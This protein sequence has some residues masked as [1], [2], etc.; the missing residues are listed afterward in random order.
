MISVFMV[1]DHKSK[2]QKSTLLFC[3]CKLKIAWLWW[4]I[5]KYI[6]H[7]PPFRPGTAL[8]TEVARKQQLEGRGANKLN[9]RTLL[10]RT[11]TQ[12]LFLLL[13]KVKPLG[14]RHND[15]S[16][17]GKALKKGRNI[18]DQSS[19]LIHN[20]CRGWIQHANLW[21][22]KFT[23]K[24]LKQPLKFKKWIIFQFW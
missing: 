11:M 3:C 21:I 23:V 24:T 1:K 2:S 7:P 10:S 18:T 9:A 16:S 13:W 12:I 5:F 17:W 22:R 6:Q 14:R 20:H 4:R 15:E 19:F 8:V